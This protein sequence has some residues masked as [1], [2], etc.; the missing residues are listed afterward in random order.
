MKLFFKPILTSILLFSSI[1]CTSDSIA[2]EDALLG[3]EKTNYTPLELRVLDLINA[4]RVT[5]G[6]T[7]L[8]KLNNIS[9]EAALHNDH[10]ISYKEACHDFFF[11]RKQKLQQVTGA[12][13]VVENVAFAFSSADAVVAAWIRSGKHKEAIEGNYTHFG[14]SAKKNEEG[15]YYF[16]N[17]FIKK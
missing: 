13:D 5:I 8:E 6:L 2:E 7:N 9:G 12:I 17:I 14:I 11:E 16:T 15:K 3:T 10:M 1:S 4:H